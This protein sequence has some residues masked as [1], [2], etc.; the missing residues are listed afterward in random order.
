M[1]TRRKAASVTMMKEEV[2]RW[3]ME[4]MKTRMQMVM[5]EEPVEMFMLRGVEMRNRC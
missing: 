2:E 5:V 3:M 4:E 1:L